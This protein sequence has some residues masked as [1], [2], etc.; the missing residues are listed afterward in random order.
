MINKDVKA[1][2]AKVRKLKEIVI[3]FINIVITYLI[4]RGY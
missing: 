2:G 3:I 1:F 4:S